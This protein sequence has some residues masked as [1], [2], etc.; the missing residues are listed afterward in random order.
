MSTNSASSGSVT[1]TGVLLDSSTP[2]VVL[3][4]KKTGKVTVVAADSFTANE[5]RFTLP[6]VESG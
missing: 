5:V 2:E 4:N 6:T 3:S 1:L